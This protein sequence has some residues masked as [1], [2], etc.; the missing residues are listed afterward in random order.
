MFLVVQ[1]QS[2]FHAK[3]VGITIYTKFRQNP[4][5]SLGV[6]VGGIRSI[7]ESS[8]V[9]FLF[10]VSWAH[11]PPSVIVCLHSDGLGLLGYKG[12][13]LGLCFWTFRLKRPETLTQ[14]YSLISHGT[15]DI[16]KTAVNTPNLAF[17]KFLFHPV[18]CPITTDAF[19]TRVQ[20]ASCLPSRRS[21]PVRKFA[22]AVACN[23]NNRTLYRRFGCY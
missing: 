2:E 7:Y 9:L 6:Q 13:P 19:L 12:V 8:D 4:S 14:R 22:C 10:K 11:L 16:N 20:H 3:C 23:V 15:W 1:L 5:V 18:Y 21:G 17:L